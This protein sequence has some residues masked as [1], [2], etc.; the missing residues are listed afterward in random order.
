MP[1]SYLLLIK[2]ILGIYTS[3]NYLLD[4]IRK[5]EKETFRARKVQCPKQF[6]LRSKFWASILHLTTFMPVSPLAALEQDA[7]NASPVFQLTPCQ[8]SM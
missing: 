7:W 5:L 4:I 2:E 3:L 6:L 1:L 8:V